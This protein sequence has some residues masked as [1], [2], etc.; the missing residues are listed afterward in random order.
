MTNNGAF[1]KGGFR[2]HQV[3]MSMIRAADAADAA[4]LEGC[5]VGAVAVDGGEQDK[6]GRW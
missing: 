2:V 4:D 6:D 1:G 3:Q 5:A